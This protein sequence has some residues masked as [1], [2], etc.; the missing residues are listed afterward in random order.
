MLLSQDDEL[1]HDLAAVNNQLQNR[2]SFRTSA[3]ADSSPQQQELT[4]PVESFNSVKSHFERIQQNFA[5]MRQG[6]T[7]TKSQL[8][9][10]V[11]QASRMQ[12]P[13]DPSPTQAAADSSGQ[14]QGDNGDIEII[15]KKDP[16]LLALEKEKEAFNP[17]VYI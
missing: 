10:W 14:A 4:D 2:M 6:I 3:A 15:D 17:E 16:I 11:S 8:S 13:P 9:E 5:Q 7:Q 1:K 12:A